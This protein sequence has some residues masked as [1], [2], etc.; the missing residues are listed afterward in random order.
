MFLLSLPRCCRQARSGAWADLGLRH[1]LLLR[2]LV[3]LS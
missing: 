1:R 2:I 3:G